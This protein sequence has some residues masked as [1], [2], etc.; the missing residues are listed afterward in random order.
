MLGMIYSTVHVLRKSH[1]GG[2]VV[3]VKGIHPE[4]SVLP[5]RLS[6]APVTQSTTMSC[7]THQVVLYHAPRESY[8][9][10]KEEATKSEVL[11]SAA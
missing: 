7:S 9:M 11:S 10:W 2:C 4:C 1:P 3:E 5:K 8:S 6:R